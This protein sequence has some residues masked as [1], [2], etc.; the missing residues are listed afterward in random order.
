[1]PTKFSIFWNTVFY[2]P[3][4]NCCCLWFPNFVNINNPIEMYFFWYYQKFGKV[5]GYKINTQKSIAFLYID[6]ERSEPEIRETI[7]FTI[8]SKIIKYLGINLPKEAKG[9]YFENYKMMMKEIKD[10]T[11]RWKD[12]PWFWIGRLSVK[13][14]L[15]SSITQCLG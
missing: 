15:G 1:M 2:L 6:N 10:E 13:M 3:M 5:V 14:T 9:L 8:A 7:S 11:N 4:H 12:T